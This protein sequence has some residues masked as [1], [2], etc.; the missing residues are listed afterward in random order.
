MKKALLKAFALLLMA[1]VVLSAYSCGGGNGAES[2]PESA[3]ASAPES[4]AAEASETASTPSAPEVSA[5]VGSDDE[6]TVEES[7]TEIYVPEVSEPVSETEPDQPGAE[8]IYRLYTSA[9]EKNGSLKNID[10]Y[11]LSDFDVKM[12]FQGET[13]NFRAKVEQTM[14]ATGL[15]GEEMA[16][17][18][19]LSSTTV[20]SDYS[21]ES[22]RHIVFDSDNVYFKE[23]PSP[24]YTVISRSDPQAQEFNRYLSEIDFSTE[25]FSAEMFNGAQL[26]E[27]EDGSK[28]I[29]LCP[30]SDA[31]Q[32]IFDSAL[33]QMNELYEY[34]GGG[35][36]SISVN[37][38]ELTITVSPEGLASAVDIVIDMEMNVSV[39]GNDMIFA[40]SGTNTVKVADLGEGTVI[41]IPE[42]VKE[43]EEVSGIEINDEI[44]GLCADA[45]DKTNE[46]LDLQ[47]EEKCVQTV[48]TDAGGL[49]SSTSV[50]TQEGVIKRH[51]I[52]PEE[53]LLETHLIF[54]SV[55]D[56]ESSTEQFD[57]F[58]DS[59]TL[60]Y[61]YDPSSP[62]T[63]VDKES[64][65]ALELGYY[66][67]E[68]TMYIYLAPVSFADAKLTENS[69]GTKT[70]VLTIDASNADEAFQYSITYDIMSYEE[71]GAED[72]AYEIT[73]ALIEITIDENGYLQRIVSQLGVDYTM[74]LGGFDVTAETIINDEIR[75]VDPGQPVEITMPYE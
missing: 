41:E 16:A 72:I 5:P 49:Y 52:I 56:G 3:A 28:L 61:R 21:G 19:R 18:V 40:F 44:Y 59:D 38:G 13:E 31:W 20:S 23:D 60:Y 75:F 70:V 35:F 45:A 58:C 66:I 62:Y 30:D 47:M 69:D 68:G 4:R 74:R 14:K 39:N 25:D 11:S 42:N 67:N 50:I 65:E 32:Q 1:A 22:V 2:A 10:Y 7:S 17:E 48:V 55:I 53:T 57:A 63:A 34:V 71:V 33:G 6:S 43:P 36:N 12:T 27:N 64:D 29:K 24:D 51:D 46:C 8:E 37:S 54:T 15:G 9:K 26:T 73:S